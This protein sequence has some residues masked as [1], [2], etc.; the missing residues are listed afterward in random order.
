MLLR[1]SL[2]VVWNKSIGDKGE[3]GM[4]KI[5]EKRELYWYWLTNIH[6]IGYQTIGKLLEQKETAEAI[7]FMN[8]KEM[9]YFFRTNQ[10]EAFIK[11]R[12]WEEIRHQ[13]EQL[14][15]K[16]IQF[17]SREH[18]CFPM[19][20][21]NIPM[22]PYGI[23]VRGKLPNP[24][25]K[26][27]AII[28][29]RYSTAYGQ[30][31]AKYFA[32]E[33]AKQGIIVI[34]GMARGIDSIAQNAALL[35]GGES[36]GVLGCGVDICYPIENFSLYEQL[37]QI[38]GILSEYPPNTKPKAGLFPMR[39]R[40][41][42]GLADGVL[43]VEAKK[44]SGTLITVD[45]ALEQGKEIYAIPG[46]AFDALSEGCNHLIQMGAKLVTDIEDLADDY[47]LESRDLSKNYE[48]NQKTLAKNQR[49]VYSCLGLEPKYIDSIVNET[50]LSV[51]EV[52]SALFELE[53]MDLIKQVVSNYYIVSK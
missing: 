33:L 29:S 17:Y 37:S 11:S 32:R 21:K 24:Y 38:G 28:G 34:S 35:A 22:A 50:K 10:K 6:G 9:D 15:Q 1:Q 13:Y 16:N 47:G 31:M 30:E 26:T 27:I 36:Y 3:N 45:W 25:K 43:I 42:S 48:N 8:Q 19:R 7:Y 53:M 46:R 2:T 44:R 18:R 52:L 4:N 20:L 23:Y 51:Q 39:N 12:N 41:I 49:V 40:L 14:R 5:E